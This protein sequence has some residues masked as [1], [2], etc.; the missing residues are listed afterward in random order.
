MLDEQRGGGG[1]G[2]G[3][4][5]EEQEGGEKGEAAHPPI[6]HNRG[7]VTSA[8]ARLRQGF[9]GQP[10][11]PPALGW[12]ASRSRAAAKAGGAEGNRTPDL[13]SAIAALSH[14]S[15]SP[16]PSMEPSDG[17]DGGSRGAQ[18]A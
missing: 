16:A 12:L 4:A 3:A 9:G 5:G 15:Y 2:S 6:V 13:C 18:I 11:S 14:L 10:S 1:S 17:A 7:Q 8:V